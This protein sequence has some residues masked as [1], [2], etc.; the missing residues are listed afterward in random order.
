M[1][2]TSNLQGE[3][4]D[5]ASLESFPNNPRIGD[6]GT[7]KE[8]LRR[9]GQYRPIVVHKPTRRVLAGHHVW[10]AAK[11]LGWETIAVS[12]VDGDETFCRKV[13]LA[14]NRTADLGSYQNDVLTDLLR[15]LPDLIATGYDAIPRMLDKELSFTKPA[16]KEV[17]PRKKVVC[18]SFNYKVDH[19]AWE[20]WHDQIFEECGGQKLKIPRQIGTRLGIELT[21]KAKN[22]KLKFSNEATVAIIETQELPIDSVEPFYRNARE[23]DIG[24][25]CESLSTL[26]QF[27]PIVV[28]RRTREILV[29]NHT[30]A[31]AKALKWKTIAVSWVDVDEETATRIVLVDNRSTDLATYDEALLRQTMINT[32]LQGTGWDHEDMNDLFSG[33]ETRAKATKRTKLKVGQYLV[34]VESET[35]LEW[36]DKLPMGNEIEHIANLLSLPI[37]ELPN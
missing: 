4:V 12:W 20:I 33:M 6:L 26:G 30:W 7:I 9:L 22:R 18:G 31:A 1:K 27:R 3:D 34:P 36:I 35:L 21:T 23:G 17:K 16:P 28:N 37:S 2:M 15:S 24:A 5:I 19:L 25:I 29:G 8:S 11:D 14:D 10:Q 32:D 13:V